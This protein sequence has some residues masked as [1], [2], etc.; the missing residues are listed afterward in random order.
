MPDISEEVADNLK[1]LTGPGSD[2]AVSLTN[3][4]RLTEPDSDMAASIK[5]L[6]LLTGTDSNLAVSIQ[7]LKTF[8]ETLNQS[9]DPASHKEHRAANRYAQ[10]GAMAARLAQHQILSRR[11]EGSG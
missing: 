3:I 4:K 5:N 10:E 1:R 11:S 8:M 9:P 7:N 6:K 2:L